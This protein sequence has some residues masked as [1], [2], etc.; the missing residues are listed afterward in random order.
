MIQHLARTKKKKYTVNTKGC[1]WSATLFSVFIEAKNIMNTPS[2]GRH[3]AL[4]PTV[5]SIHCT[6][7][8]SPLPCLTNN[9]QS[10]TLNLYMANVNALLCVY[11]IHVQQYCI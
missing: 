6:A 4:F 3:E 2:I 5:L 9:M 8:M 7:E 11:L 1:T 10:Y